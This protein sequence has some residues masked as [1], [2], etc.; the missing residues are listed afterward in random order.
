MRKVEPL[1]PQSSGR[2]GAV[3]FSPP[4]KI[5]VFSWRST[6][7]LSSR[8]HESVDAQS[9]AVEK[10]EISVRSSASA[11]MS[12]ARCDIDLSP[13]KRSRPVRKCAGLSLITGQVMYLKGHKRQRYVIN[14]ASCQC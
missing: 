3:N 10:F 13:G 12:A 8:K 1:F 6:E 2:R 14:S 5:T 9:A 11:A 7:M 4:A